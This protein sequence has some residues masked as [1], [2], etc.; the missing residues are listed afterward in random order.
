MDSFAALVMIGSDFSIDER[1]TSLHDEGKPLWEF[2]EHHWRLY[3]HRI[4]S[5]KTVVIILL[6]GWKKDK[7]GRRTAEEKVEIQRAQNLRKEYME[8]TEERPK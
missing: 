5:G 2:K 8:S 3:C 6:N 1:F 4:Q 7:K